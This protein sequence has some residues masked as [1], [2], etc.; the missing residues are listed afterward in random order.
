[1]ASWLF[2]SS[3]PNID[4]YIL[5]ATS[6]NL[7]TGAQDLALNLEICD[8][9]RSKTVPPKD[10]MRSLKRRLLHKNPNVQ[11]ATLHLVDV[12]IM[13]GGTHFLVEISSREFMDTVVLVLKPLTGP[14]NPDVKALALECIQN[15]AKT[16]EG[17]LQL[18]YTGKVYRQLKD[19]GKFFF[20]ICYC[21]CSS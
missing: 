18:E 17:Q 16:F 6:E 3:G 4:E 10:A 19:E 13:N 9:I 8:L 12:C 21:Y 7:P 15:W 1:M 11:L 2:S 14:P 5:K 20:L